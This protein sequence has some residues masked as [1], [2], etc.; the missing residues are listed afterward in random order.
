MI[1]KERTDGKKEGGKE[2]KKEGGREGGRRGKWE[3]GRE[4]GNWVRLKG[5]YLPVC[6]CPAVFGSQR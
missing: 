2:K 6:V 4:E 3:G 5:L 1:W